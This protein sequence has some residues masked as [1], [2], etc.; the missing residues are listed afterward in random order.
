MAPKTIEE[1]RAM[2]HLK[3]DE[4]IDIIVRMGSSGTRTLGGFQL[5]SDMLSIVGLWGDKHMEMAGYLTEAL[6]VLA[7]K[8][9]T[10]V[11]S[12]AFGRVSESEVHAEMARRHNQQ[13]K[14]SAN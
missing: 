9:G 8:A 2:M 12:A 10:V 1:Q 7:A 14:P 6:G 3:L 5:S 11:A 4:A 13:H